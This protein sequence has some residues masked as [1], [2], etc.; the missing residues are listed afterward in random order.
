MYLSM[1]NVLSPMVTCSN[2]CSDHSEG[3]NSQ[4]S[5]TVTKT[6]DLFEGISHKNNNCGFLLDHNQ[7]AI[8]MVNMFAN[9]D[10]VM[11]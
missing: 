5:S 4:Y 7:E 11:D 6:C 9:S 1:K 2:P 8:I 3:I 10:S